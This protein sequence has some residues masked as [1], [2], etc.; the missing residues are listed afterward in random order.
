MEKDLILKLH[1]LS[2]ELEDMKNIIKNQ[3]TNDLNNISTVLLYKKIED[4]ILDNIGNASESQIQ[5]LYSYKF[6]YYNHLNDKNNL[7]KELK[8]ILRNK[9]ID[10]IL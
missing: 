9:K 8:T 2:R 1:S 6:I 10:T 7:D 3:N 4:G 5:S